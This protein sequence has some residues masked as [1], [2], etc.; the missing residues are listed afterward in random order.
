MTRPTVTGQGGVA[1]VN[2]AD[3]VSVTGSV[4]VAQAAKGSRLI[5]ANCNDLQ[6]DDS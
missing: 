2:G 4:R 5:G 1:P 6:Q 3:E